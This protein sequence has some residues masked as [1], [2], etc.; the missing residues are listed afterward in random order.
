M[1]KHL[2]SR[3]RRRGERGVTMLMVMTVLAALIVATTKSLVADMLER[4]EGGPTDLPRAL[5]F[6]QR[7]VSKGYAMAGLD[8][9]EMA[10]AHPDVFPDR[11]EAL[12]YCLWAEAQPALPGMASYAGRCDAAM[13]ELGPEERAEARVMANSF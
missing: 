11:V 9:A 1:V 13:A 4:G 7:A 6:Y 10:W 3:S 5:E 12:A 2:R 8:I